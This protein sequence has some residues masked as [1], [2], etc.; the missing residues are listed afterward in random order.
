ML[1][2]LSDVPAEIVAV[3]AVGKLSRQDY[4]RV[5]EP[6]F[7]DT[8]REGRRLRFLYELGPE[9]EGFTP[10][11]AWEDFKLGLRSL[12]LLAGCALVTDREWIREAAQ[13]A[14]FF[15]PCP[16]KVFPSRDRDKA[17]AWLGS[18]PH[19]VSVVHR[20]L[21]DKGVLII[22][23]SGPLHAQDFDALAVTVDPWIESHGDLNGVVIH[24]R[25]FPGWENLGSL[26]RHVQFV[27]DHHRKVRRI[28]LAV[29]GKLAHLAPRMGEHFVRAEV[30]TFAH[31]QIDAA[32]LWASGRSEDPRTA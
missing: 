25:A 32:I 11:A 5:L 14:G 20:L 26:V 4:E 29:D 12:R 1:E 13:I 9:F 10:G 31:D 17:V 24:A 3:K 18:I 23:A 19:Q 21:T 30:K 6:L 7:A 2:K 15:V 22:E 8:R 16:V 27:R 28:A